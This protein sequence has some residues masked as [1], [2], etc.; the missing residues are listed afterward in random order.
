MQA[1]YQSSPLRAMDICFLIGYVAHRAGGECWAYDSRTYPCDFSDTSGKECH[2]SVITILERARLTH[3]GL[4]V[5]QQAI[6]T[7]TADIAER[8]TAKMFV[9]LTDNDVNCGARGGAPV[10][11]IMDAARRRLFG[12]CGP[13]A[14]CVLHTVALPGHR[15]M[16]DTGNHLNS[17]VASDAA[18]SADVIDTLALRTATRNFTEC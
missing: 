9:F 3:G 1:V 14:T 2:Q 18:T 17:V 6:E 4:T 10:D 11:T 5:P 8:R 15:T 12:T 7:V 16:F 13:I